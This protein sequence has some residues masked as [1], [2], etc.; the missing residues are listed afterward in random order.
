MS[1]QRRRFCKTWFWE[2]NSGSHAHVASARAVS[3]GLTRKF[4]VPLM[5]EDLTWPGGLRCAAM[6][7]TTL[8]SWSPSSSSR[9]WAYGR[10]T[11]I[12]SEGAVPIREVPYLVPVRQRG[13][14]RSW[15]A[16]TAYQA[17]LASVLSAGVPLLGPSVA[18]SVT[19]GWS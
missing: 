8:N 19:C 11:M 3:F 1:L 10:V 6:P 15:R 17:H 9:C 12:R 5:R 13:R 18:P 14:L 4:M 2:Q 7:R 16:G